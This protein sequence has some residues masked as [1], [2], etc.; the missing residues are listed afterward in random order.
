LLSEKDIVDLSNKN[1]VTLRVEGH[2]ILARALNQRVTNEVF[3]E[4][5]MKN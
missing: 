2:E 1:Y 3:F 5:Y 4:Q